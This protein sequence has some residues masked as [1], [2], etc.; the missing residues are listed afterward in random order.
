MVNLEAELK[1][2]TPLPGKIDLLSTDC[3]TSAG[4]AVACTQLSLCLRYS[5][6]GVPDTLE[7]EAVVELDTRRLTTPRMLLLAREGE[8]THRTTL[9][10]AKEEPTCQSL[11]VYL[12]PSIRDKL[13]ALEATL[14]CSL[15]ATTSPLPPVLGR[16]EE[17]GV[18]ARDQVSNISITIITIMTITIPCTTTCAVAAVHP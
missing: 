12:L 15:P 11:E 8:S 2:L 6:T 10:L 9:T 5:D 4:E 16:G 14:A 1:F 17:G 18:T 7:V 13:T 3:V